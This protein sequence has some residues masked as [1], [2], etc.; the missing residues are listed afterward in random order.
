MVV[1][2]KKAGLAY[3]SIP[4]CACSSLKI[5]FHEVETGKTWRE[6]K[7]EY[8]ARNEPKTIHEEYPPEPATQDLW[9]RVEGY[10]KICVVRGPVS[11]LLSCYNNKVVEEKVLSRPVVRSRL[12]AAGLPHQPDFETFVDNLDGYQEISKSIARHSQ[13][14]EHWLGSDADRF[15]KIFSMK[16]LSEFGDW[17]KQRVADVPE[18][19][20]SNRS[21]G[22]TKPAQIDPA[23]R[24]RIKS[25]YASDIE[26]YG[27]WL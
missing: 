19:R 13:P 16:G 20:H 21:K 17:M 27:P 8:I 15:T 18:L 4:K 14:L 25:R 22:G 10:D 5:F 3:F 12:V 1:V 24:Q 23:V 11:R 26:V 7:K 9:D 2:C 6:T